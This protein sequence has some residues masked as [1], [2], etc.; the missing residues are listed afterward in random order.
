MASK[1]RGGAQK[2]AFDYLQEIIEERVAHND[3][4]KQT[5]RI[6]C[7]VLK[8]F[9][10]PRDRYLKGWLD[11]HFPS[12]GV[13]PKIIAFYGRI[14]SNNSTLTSAIPNP[15]L[16]THSS[17]GTA[18]NKASGVKALDITTSVINNTRDLI[19]EI[20]RNKGSVAVISKWEIEK[21]PAKIRV[22]Y[23]F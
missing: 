10:P 20:A 18:L 2:D 11:A 21:I 4:S 7:T 8:V 23:E 13:P 3:F 1:K 16:W 12:R 17:V 6:R 22:L 19:N 5:H 14:Q 15:R 9:E